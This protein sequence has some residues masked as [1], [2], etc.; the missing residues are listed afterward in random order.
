[1]I[2]EKKWADRLLQACQQVRSARRRTVAAGESI[3]ST[4]PDG[5]CWVVAAGYVKLLDPRPTAIDSSG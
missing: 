4:T 2:L 3:F 1:M 5:R